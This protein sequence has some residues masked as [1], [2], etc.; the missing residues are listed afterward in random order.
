MTRILVPIDFSDTAFNAL[1]YAV[2]LA[3][4]LEG[5]IIVLYVHKPELTVNAM[6]LGE[7][8]YEAMPVPAIVH[9]RMKEVKELLKT[10]GVKSK[11]YVKEGFL[12]ESVVE[13]AVKKHADLVVTGTDG[14]HYAY[15][16]LWG[17][18]SSALVDEKKIPVLVIP[19][20]YTHSLS[21]KGEIVFATDF[22]GI[23][24]VPAFFI[25]MIE[26]LHLKVSVFYAKEPHESEDVKIYEKQK[27]DELIKILNSKDI[28]VFHTYKTDVVDAVEDFVG[29]RNAQ[30]VVMISQ[31][32]SFFENLFHKSV[33]H[34][35][36]LH[37]HVP[38]LAIPDLEAEVNTSYSN[39]GFIG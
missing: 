38:F 5:E 6:P 1:R 31:K 2:S 10:T 28:S 22:K 16:M 11:A 14:V 21:S 3:K 24:D 18:H 34:Q 8:Y 15:H 33:T 27:I 35:M 29:K 25:D 32:R 37:S 39:S 19:R 23:E 13:L 26:K 4:I 12:T 30:M 9:T 17:T 20:K 7:P 36:A